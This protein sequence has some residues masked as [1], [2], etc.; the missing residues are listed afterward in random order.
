MGERGWEWVGRGEK[1]GLCKTFNN[2]DEKKTNKTHTNV[3][4]KKI[5]IPINKNCNNKKLSPW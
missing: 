4:F 3:K 5:R 2:K 1:E